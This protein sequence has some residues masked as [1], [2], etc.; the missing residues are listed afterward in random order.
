MM[1]DKL[2]LNLILYKNKTETRR[3]Y[4]ENQRPAIPG[5][6]HKLKI[7][8]SPKTYGYIKIDEVTTQKF[9]EITFQDAI[10]E[11]FN[12]VKEYKQY[13]QEVN[14]KHNDND[15]IYVIKFHLIKK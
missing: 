14:G 11:G 10:N 15:L 3:K 5:N 9:G 8:R 12:S 1:F 13:F 2:C 4:K 6:I 7:D